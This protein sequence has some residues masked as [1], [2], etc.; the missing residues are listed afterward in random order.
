MT[1]TLNVDR[2]WLGKREFDVRG[3]AVSFVAV[4][5]TASFISQN[6]GLEPLVSE[7]ER[8]QKPV[9]VEIRPT[10]WTKKLYGE[11]WV[12]SVNQPWAEAVHVVLTGTGPLRETL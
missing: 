10:G 6:E 9:S 4:G 12:T 7:A 2:I 1:T 3:G 5:W 8:T 11:A